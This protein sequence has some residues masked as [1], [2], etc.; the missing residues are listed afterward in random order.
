LIRTDSLVFRVEKVKKK[1]E[2]NGL[3]FFVSINAVRG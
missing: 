2:A 1:G 3:A